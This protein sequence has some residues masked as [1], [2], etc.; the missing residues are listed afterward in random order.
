MGQLGRLFAYGLNDGRV[1]VAKGIGGDAGQ[2]ISI[3]FAGGVV[4]RAALPV[5]EGDRE[6]R[7]EGV[8]I[9][10]FVQGFDLLYR[11]GLYLLLN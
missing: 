9:I 3:G 5:G 10:L 6:A 11:H 7:A 1:G 4:Q 8:H 2:K